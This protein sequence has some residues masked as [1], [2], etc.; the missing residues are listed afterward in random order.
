M[1]FVVFFYKIINADVF[2]DLSHFLYIVTL[3]PLQKWQTPYK[4][5]LFYSA[6]LITSNKKAVKQAIARL[7]AYCAVQR[8]SPFKKIKSKLH[9]ILYP[10][11]TIRHDNNHLRLLLHF[12]LSALLMQ[13]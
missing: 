13:A 11:L 8:E 5:G 2:A 4:G 1:Q 12:D 9:F 3:S 7:T 10:S 6:N